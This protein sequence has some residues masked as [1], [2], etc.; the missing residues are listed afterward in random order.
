MAAAGQQSRRARN[1]NA[2]ANGQLLAIFSRIVSRLVLLAHLIDS[3]LLA[4]RRECLKLMR[5][6][7]GISSR[8]LP[9]HRCDAVA[10]HKFAKAP[11]SPASKPRRLPPVS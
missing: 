8:W 3:G 6:S 7:W 2:T 11:S 9:E 5:F 10:Q 4:S 1:N